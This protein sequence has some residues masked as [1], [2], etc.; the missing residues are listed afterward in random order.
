M[1]S[2]RGDNQCGQAHTAN[3]GD[4]R[5]TRHGAR[6]EEGLDCRADARLT[7]DPIRP[8]GIGFGK[9]QSGDNPENG[10]GPHR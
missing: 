4:F 6:F 3:S 10:R 9:G 2:K 5:F 1:I 8:A 7:I